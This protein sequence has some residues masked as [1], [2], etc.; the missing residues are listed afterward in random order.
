M[1]CG[2]CLHE[3]EPFAGLRRLAAAV[4][5]YHARMS[6]RQ[7]PDSAAQEEALP[8]TA[9]AAGG[10]G[11][12]A[13]GDG[14]ELPVNV[15]GPIP[16]IMLDLGWPLTALKGIGLLCRTA[17]L[18]A[19]LT[20]EADRL[21]CHGEAEGVGERLEVVE[22][23]IAEREV[24]APGDAALNGVFDGPAARQSA[25]GVA[26]G[27]ALHEA[28]QRD[29]ACA[30]LARIEG[31]G[32]VVVG[33]GVETDDPV[34]LVTPGGEDQ[35]GEGLTHAAQL[36]DKIQTV[37]TRQAKIDDGDIVMVLGGPVQGFF[38]AVHGVDNMP[39]LGEARCQMVAQQCF[40]FD[41]Q[42]L[43]VIL[44]LQDRRT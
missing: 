40:V 44:R 16:A 43:H 2:S 6:E 34:E 14:R 38:G 37:H 39:H 28:Q 25:S 33:A 11:N 36:P 24:P 1:T 27:L 13:P 3:A 22:V 31:L 19:H 9:A 42:E 20:E 26:I 23:Q 35:D 10:A 32:Q 15:N 18:V 4:G 21:V 29:H 12:P 8:E 41:Q 17:G 7:H 5:R 30:Q